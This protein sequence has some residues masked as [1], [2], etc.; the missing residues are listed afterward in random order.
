MKKISIW[1]AVAVLFAS[2]AALPAFASSDDFV[3]VATVT[4]GTILSI[5]TGDDPNF[6]LAFSD[7]A[8]G[9]FSQ[10]KFVNYIVRANNMTTSALTGAVSAK[11]NAALDGITIVNT[12]QTYVND[13]TSS[14]A[15][16]T[17][18]GGGSPIAV[19]TTSV[20][21]YN[22]PT[23][24][25]AEGKILKGQAPT[26]WQARADRDLAPGDGGTVTITVTLK[27]S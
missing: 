13:G 25:G 19:G 4:V 1:F 9:A 14:N 12:P 8:S 26:Y 24:S 11:I 23:S 6:T 15:V 18:L 21:L 17:E 22:K 27:D 3:H 7:F 16:L 2:V 5:E 10:G 20:N